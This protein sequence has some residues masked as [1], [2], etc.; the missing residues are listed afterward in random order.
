MRP[1]EVLENNR[2]AIREATKR[3]NAANPRVFG[4]VA[5]GEDGPDSDLDILVDALPG[6]TLFDLGGLLEE[7]KAVLGVKV[8]VVTAGG[9]HASIKERVL[10][11]AKPV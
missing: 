1:S 4:S 10:R 3:F 2:Q 7:L 5:R 6:T 11:E 9:L 8:D